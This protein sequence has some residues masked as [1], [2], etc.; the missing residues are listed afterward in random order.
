MAPDAPT[1]GLT[2]ST[3]VEALRRGGYATSFSIAEG[4]L[5]CDACGETHLVGAVEVDHV[6]REEGASDP[7]D[8]AIVVG[9]TCPA[10]GARGTLVAAYGPG[11][12]REEAEVLRAL[13]TT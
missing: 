2:E 7:D 13:P 5:H 8:E 12:S 3:A 6:L 10:C 4:G 9:L 1:G 11:A